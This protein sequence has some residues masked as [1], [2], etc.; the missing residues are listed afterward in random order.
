MSVRLRGIVGPVV[1]VVISVCLLAGRALAQAQPPIP[2][3]IEYTREVLDNGLTVIYAPLRQAPVVHVQLAYHVGSRDERP[4][5]QGFAHMFEH[6]M[7]R[8]SAHVPPEL[9]MRYIAD[10]GGYANAYTSFDQTMYVNTVPSQ[11]LEMILWL[12]ADRMASFTVSPEI[13][14]TERKV[15]AEEWRMRQNQPYG[16]MYEDFLKNA[17]L[18]HSYR[19]TPI[20]NMEHLNAADASELQEFFNTY[21]VPDNAV[22]TI[23]GDFDVEQ[24]RGLVRTYLGWIPRGENVDR[25]VPEEPEQTEQRLATV[26]QRVPQAALLIGYKLPGY[27]SDESYALTLLSTIMGGGDSSRLDRLLVNNEAPEAMRAYSM[28]F[29]LQDYGIFGVGAMVLMGKDADKVRQEIEQAVADVVA[30]GVTAEELDKART[31][32]IVELIRAREQADDIAS[33]LSEEQLIGGDAERANQAVGRYQAVTPADV[34]AVAARYLRPERATVLNIKP[35]MFA[36]PATSPAPSTQASP[37]SRTVAPRVIEFPAGYPTQAPQAGARQN[38]E[39]AKGTEVPGTGVQTIIMPDH[40][41]P[42]VNWTLV[43]RRGSHAE[44]TGKEGLAGLTAALVQRGA[45]GMNFMELSQ[46]MESRGISISVSDGGDTTRL[47]GSSTTD[48]LDHALLRSRQ[49]LREPALPADEFAKLQEQT[50]NELVLSQENPDTVAS[51][52]LRLA[53]YGADSPLG[54]SATPQ[55]VRS[56]TLDEVKGFYQTIYRPEGAV[57]LISGDIT[58]ERGTDLA[59]KLLG[60]WPAGE[61]PQVTYPP[62]SQPTGR[63]II[64]VDRPDAKQSVVRMAI[65]AYT[66]QSDDKFPGSVANQILNAGLDARLNKYVRAEK[67]LAYS[68]YG[69]F[70][71]GR[72]AGTFQGGTDTKLESTADTVEAMFQVFAGMREQN[73]TD[74]ELLAAQTRVAGSMVMNMQT[75]AQQAGF[76]VDGILNSYPI[77]YYDRYPQRIADV[78]ADQVRAVM[79]RY[80]KDDAMTIV[81]VAPAE[82]VKQQLERLGTVQVVPMPAR[83]EPATRPA[84]Q[85]LKP[86]A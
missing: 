84:T 78:T 38:P 79:Q 42:L 24:A 72:Q 31:Q 10:V 86:A 26:P 58:T 66:I 67:G 7:F 83:R 35:S 62:V 44:P 74:K 71:A 40:R 65:P 77:D 16:T 9:H 64:L 59:A 23:A 53:I 51:R 46:D 2:Q 19:W 76:R 57:L 28:H 82:K 45:A 21:Y 75:I 18:H 32:Q 60:D 22:L 47:S 30:N 73:V 48:Q 43:M 54:R 63:T 68:V 34:Q 61:L 85:A 20:G 17:F 11:H 29:Q 39:F 69:T 13:Y 80:V 4:D 56:I 6:M 50:A 15:V 14:A 5:R 33:Q 3:P 41:L 70:N 1:W 81:V 8:G 55:S 36:A 27:G 49:I 37:T 25:S 12:E 52:D